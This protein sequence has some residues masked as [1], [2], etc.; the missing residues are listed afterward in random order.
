MFPFVTED[1]RLGWGEGTEA[2]EAV[3][4]EDAGEGSFRDGEGHADLGVGAALFAERQDLSFERGGSFARL[5][6]RP[7]GMIGQAR[8][9]VGGVGAR[10][11]LAD[12]F[13]TN[14][15]GGGGG[16]ERGA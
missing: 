9:E 11:P 8:W 5:L 3:A 4:L 7:G 14:A 1:G 6:V 12:G 10:E 13:V 15:E 16:A 2:L